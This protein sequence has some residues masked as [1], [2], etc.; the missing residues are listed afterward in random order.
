MSHKRFL[1][2]NYNF[3]DPS[4]S[5]YNVVNIRTDVTTTTHAFTVDVK[6]AFCFFLRNK[7][8]SF[9]EKF[10]YIITPRHKNSSC[11]IGRYNALFFFFFGRQAGYIFPGIYWELCNLTNKRNAIKFC[12]VSVNHISC[13]LGSRQQVLNVLFKYIKNKTCDFG[14]I[15]IE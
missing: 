7:T 13:T 10:L 9:N 11:I 5:R 2:F 14:T 1:N 3:G 4:S 12:L 8:V 6:F 15:K